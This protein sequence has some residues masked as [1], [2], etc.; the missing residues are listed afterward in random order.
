MLCNASLFRNKN[1]TCPPSPLFS[2][3]LSLIVLAIGAVF[4][5][6][7]HLGTQET[8]A[9]R[10][11]DEEDGSNEG[12]RQPLL[13]RNTNAPSTPLQWRH[14]LSEPSFYQVPPARVQ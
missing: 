14:W 13:T 9:V 11:Q 6:V 8:E 5:V 4:S 1:P 7:F 10:R 12:E 2:Q 3:D